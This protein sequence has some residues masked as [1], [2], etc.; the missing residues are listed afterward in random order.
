MKMKTTSII[1]NRKVEKIEKVTTAAGTFD[2]YVIYSDSQTQAMG[3]IRTYPS[4][5]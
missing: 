4:R 3:I 5:L 1:L 2:C